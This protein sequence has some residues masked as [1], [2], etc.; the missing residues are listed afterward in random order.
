MKKEI[1]LDEYLEKL[2][3]LLEKESVGARAAL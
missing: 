1:S 2:K 3:Q